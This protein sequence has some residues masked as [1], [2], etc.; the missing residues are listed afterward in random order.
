M[1]GVLEVP[2]GMLGELRFG[3]HRLLGQ[4]VRDM[5]VIAER[6]DPELHEEWYRDPLRRFDR[7]RALLDLIGWRGTGEP[8]AVDVDLRAHRWALLNA[9]GS[10][11]ILGTEELY[12]ADTN[13]AGSVPSPQCDNTLV[14]MVV[15]NDFLVGVEERAGIP[16]P[17]RAIYSE[18]PTGRGPSRRLSC[19]QRRPFGKR[20]RRMF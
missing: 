11:L 1:S 20:T 9:L 15:L 8:Q 12:G 18:Q 19:F 17:W 3:L 13:P 16:T 10:A 6:P 4:A 5:A 14:R 2:A 7:A